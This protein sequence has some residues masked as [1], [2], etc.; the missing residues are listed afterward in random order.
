[1]PDA[2]EA[3]IVKLTDHGPQ[4]PAKASEYLEITHCTESRPMRKSSALSFD[5]S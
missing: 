5:A 4:P 3:Q 2:D 1:V